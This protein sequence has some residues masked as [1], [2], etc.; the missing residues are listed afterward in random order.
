MSGDFVYVTVQNRKT[1]GIVGEIHDITTEKSELKQSR[2]SL[3]KITSSLG[4]TVFSDAYTKALIA[5]STYYGVGLGYSA[6]ALLSSHFLVKDYLQL[7]PI[8]KESGKKNT[9]LYIEAD[10][11]ERILFYKKTVEKAFTQNKSILIITP[12]HD[13]AS[14]FHKALASLLPKEC[15]L[16]QTGEVPKKQL[17]KNV[18]LITNTQKSYCVIGTPSALFLPI[19]RLSMVVVEYEHSHAYEQGVFPFFDGRVVAEAVSRARNVPVLFADSFVRIETRERTTLAF[20]TKKAST[21]TTIQDQKESKE[22]TILSMTAKKTV[23]SALDNNQSIFIFAFRKGY[24]GTTICRDCGEGVRCPTCNKPLTLRGSEAKK[25]FECSACK[26]KIDSKLTCAHCGSWNIL[27]IGIGVDTVV[28]ELKKIVKKEALFIIDGDTKKRE[29]KQQLATFEKSGG[30]LVGNEAALLR[31]HFKVTYSIIASLDSLFSIPSYSANERVGNIIFK[32]REKTKDQVLIQTRY[33]D[34]T[35]FTS[36]EAGAKDSF[37]KNEEATRKALGYPPYKTLLSIT[38]QGATAS[39]ERYTDLIKKELKQY[40]PQ[41]QNTEKY[42]GKTTST[43]TMK[44]PKEVWSIEALLSP[45][46]ETAQI[47]Y[48]LGE[49][50]KEALIKVN[51]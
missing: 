29:T 7:P 26:T 8:K 43:V 37:I 27:P 23:L 11:E 41:I 46:K 12:T 9:P 16:L 6:Y 13:L 15:I 47:Q 36:L 31:L 1:I 25:V 33:K 48:L 42:P 32:I 14:F 10:E 38:L 28:E 40:S 50:P 5:I 24:A 34:E 45:S 44:L 49:L 22:H 39:V 4:Q 30:V 51:K 35:I 19:T 20:G 3:K 17:E 18:S 21:P 2:F